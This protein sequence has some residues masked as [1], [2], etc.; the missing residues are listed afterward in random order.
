MNG[1]FWVGGQR[2]FQLN[3]FLNKTSLKFLEFTPKLLQ[4]HKSARSP[5][6][7][8]PNLTIFV[9]RYIC[10]ICDISQ[11]G[12]SRCHAFA[13]TRPKTNSRKCFS[14]GRHESFASGG[15]EK[16]FPVFSRV[17]RFLSLKILFLSESATFRVCIRELLPA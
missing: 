6:L 17:V 11:L 14:L 4:F 5:T 10:H 1:Y 3:R 16:Y 2:Y 9:H 8:Y 15:P 7:F 13:I 12:H